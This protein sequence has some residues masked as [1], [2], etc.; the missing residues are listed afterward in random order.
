MKKFLILCLLLTISCQ[1]SNL[2]KEIVDIIKCIL[3]SGNFENSIDKL[4]KAINS[5]DISKM[6]DIG[7]SIFNGL[8]NEV[9]QCIKKNLR[10]LSNEGN[11]DYDDIRLGYPKYV[12]VLYSQIGERAFEWYEQGGIDYLKQ[13]CHLYYGQTTWYCLYLQKA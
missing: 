1:S 5:K 7:I 13:Q 9:G 6:I 2:I 12:Y 10:K 4:I 11:K 8:N 3:K